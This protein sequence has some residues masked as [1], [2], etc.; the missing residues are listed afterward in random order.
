MEGRKVD[1]SDFAGR[2]HTSMPAR[3]GT[4]APIHPTFLPHPGSLAGCILLPILCA[5]LGLWLANTTKE[6][7][8]TVQSCVANRLATA[9]VA[10]T[11]SVSVF[12][13]VSTMRPRALCLLRL[14]VGPDSHLGNRMDTHITNVGLIILVVPG[15][16]L[17]PLCS[18]DTSRHSSGSTAALGEASSPA[19]S[20]HSKSPQPSDDAEVPALDELYQDDAVVEL[21]FDEEAEVPWTQAE[22]RKYLEEALAEER[23]QFAHDNRMC[24]TGYIF[25]Y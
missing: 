2:V 5:R 4:W 6:K 17:C 23:A 22:L 3:F 21:L 12:L 25:R 10:G 18:A 19:P 14:L 9:H 11:I 16:Y 24:N 15:V 1:R 7:F 13:V 20:S 8:A